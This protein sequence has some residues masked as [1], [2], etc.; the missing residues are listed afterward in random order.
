MPPVCGTSANKSNHPPPTG[1]DR[2]GHSKWLLYQ[3]IFCMLLKE[4]AE[5]CWHH[6]EN[7]VSL[8]QAYIRFSTGR[9]RNKRLYR[10]AHVGSQKRFD[11]SNLRCDGYHA[12]TDED[13]ATKGRRAITTFILFYRT[14]IIYICIIF[15]EG[16]CFSLFL[17]LSLPSCPSTFYSMIVGSF[18]ILDIITR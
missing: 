16:H 18:F 12:Q 2:G 13:G 1:G 3:L 15:G 14:P 9:C 17:S 8:Q 4:L 10:S 5:S 6:Q 7:L 11:H